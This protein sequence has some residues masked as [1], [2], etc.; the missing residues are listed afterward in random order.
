MSDDTDFDP[1]AD[2]D[3]EQMD[4]GLRKIAHHVAYYR[5]ALMEE[6]MDRDDSLAASSTLAGYL[7]SET[8]WFG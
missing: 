6:G 8:I 7:F 2:H 1:M 3:V 4:A 5:A